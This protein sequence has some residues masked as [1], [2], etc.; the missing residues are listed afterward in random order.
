M[1]TSALFTYTGDYLTPYLG[2]GDEQPRTL[3]VKLKASTVYAKGTVLG[4]ITASPGTFAPYADANAD[5]TQT[6]RAI[7]PYA[8]ATDAS[9][10]ITLGSASGGD[11]RQHTLPTVPVYVGAAEFH[12]TDLTG[13]D[14]A[15][16]ADLGRL[17]QGTVADG[18]LRLP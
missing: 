13:L 11:D 8:C 4:E 16:V 10:D 6:A 3:V 15:A 2:G 17:V 9:G 7:L 18:I 5:G 12:T 14:A 1:P